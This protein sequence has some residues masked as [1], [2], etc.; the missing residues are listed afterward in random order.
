MRLIMMLIEFA[1]AVS[2]Y[3]K[4]Y[5]GEEYINYIFIGACIFIAG[6]NICVTIKDLV[7][8]LKRMIK[9][10]AIPDNIVETLEKE[11]GGEAENG[12]Q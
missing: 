12:E 9:P 1:I 6:Y 2:I 11:A 3:G 4:Y 5:T 8:D 10:I 7:Y